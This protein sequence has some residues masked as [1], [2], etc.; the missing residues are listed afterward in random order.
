MKNKNTNKGK[1]GGKAVAKTYVC[2]EC[3]AEFRSMKD[4]RRH[5]E[6]KHGDKALEEKV[7]EDALTSKVHKFVKW[8]IEQNVV[9]ARYTEE[10][11]QEDWKEA[12]GEGGISL[13]E[14]A[15]GLERLKELYRRFG[16]YLDFFVHTDDRGGIREVV[17]AYDDPE[18]YVELWDGDDCVAAS[19][20][21]RRWIVVDFCEKEF[22]VVDDIMQTDEPKWFGSS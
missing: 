3:G 6:E 21:E 4:L 8:N 1:A 16:R 2:G 14:F 11:L 12:L 20:F 19:P 10:E 5:V 7:A 18:D 13:K 17:V 15:D 22:W 9:I